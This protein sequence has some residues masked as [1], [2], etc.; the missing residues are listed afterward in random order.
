MNEVQKLQLQ[1]MVAI[2]NVEDQTSLIRQLKHSI[3]LRN[4]TQTLILLKAKYR[5]NI[6]EV[7]KNAMNECTFLFT[8]Y[9]DIFNKILKDELDMRLFTQFLD[10]LKEIEDEKLDQH[11]GSFKIGS[12][13]KE[14][15][16]DSALKKAEKAD[17]EYNA[18]NNAVSSVRTAEIRNISWKSWKSWKEFHL[19]N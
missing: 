3:I 17:I 1:K 2:N 4:E 7:K 11:E 12:I 8:Y 14:M 18:L 13:L 5:S 9:T 16:V 6:E 10:V 19:K 15:Y